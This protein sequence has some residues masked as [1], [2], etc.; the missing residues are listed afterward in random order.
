M[1]LP[2][3]TLGTGGAITWLSGG[4]TTIGAPTLT[5]TSATN[6]P[7]YVKNAATNPTAEKFTAVVTA[8]TGDGL[9]L[10]G[11]AK[12]AVCLGTDGSVTAL[13]PLAAK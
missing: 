4:S 5:P 3:L 10:P 2:A 6:C 7:G 9:K 13:K 8:D 1:A 12:G 11:S